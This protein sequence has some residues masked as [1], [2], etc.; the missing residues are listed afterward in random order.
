MKNKNFNIILVLL[1]LFISFS[2]SDDRDPILEKANAKAAQFKSAPS[3]TYIVTETNLPNVFETFV[4]TPPKYNI[5]TEYIYQ[6]EAA[7]SGT[8]FE[9]PVNL[10]SSTNNEYIKIKYSEINAVALSLG[11]TNLVPFSIDVR[12]K[13]N[14]KNTTDY[15]YSSAATFTVTPF[16]AG[17]IYNYIDL[18]LIGD[19]TAANWDNNANNMNMFPLLK[20]KANQNVYTFTGYFK[21]GGFKI[22]P[23]KGDWSKQYGFSSPGVLAVNDGGSGNIPVSSNGYYK[24]T[25]NTLAATYTLESLPDP[26]NTYS[27]ISIIGTVNGNWN[28]DTDL[29]LSSGDS[30]IW[31]TTTTL[32]EGEFKF[33]ANHDWAANWGAGQ[34]FFGTG[35][36]NG[37]NIPLAKGWK[38]NIYFNDI[39]GDYTLIPVFD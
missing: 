28:T 19:A 29:T 26:T 32:N 31:Y 27:A 6:L 18:F 34:E 13:S 35:T 3:G 5:N 24:L 2:C 20:D 8:N 25:V 15:L 21:T 38:Y 22:L 16:V 1:T 23:T 33:R 4:I 10:G 9:N 36:N 11:A 7:K 14:I 39:T 37:P 12:I 17:P 30:H